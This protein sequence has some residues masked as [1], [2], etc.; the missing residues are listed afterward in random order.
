M[1]KQQLRIPGP[2]GRDPHQLSMELWYGL[3]VSVLVIVAGVFFWL[4]PHWQEE[5][6]PFD[7]IEDPVEREVARDRAELE[8]LVDRE[9]HASSDWRE[10]SRRARAF[11]VG[12]GKLTEFLC[13][14]ELEAMRAGEM[15]EGEVEALV[16]RVRRR[17]TDAPWTCLMRE[18][19]NGDLGEEALNEAL[20]EAWAEVEALEGLGLSMAKAV[21]TY[22]EERNRPE[23]ERF[24]RWLRRC[25]IHFEYGASGEC[26]RLG[27]Q[28]APE[29]GADLLEMIDEHLQEE[30]SEAEILEVAGALARMAK[31][32]QPEAWK[33]VE[34][35]FL[36]DYNVDF[37]LGS[38]FGLCRLMNSPDP[39]ISREVSEYL[40]AVAGATSRAAREYTS[41]RW[42][43]TCRMAFGDPDKPQEP[44]PML[45]VV[46]IR[47]FEGGREVQEL[48][49][50]LA[51]LIEWGHCRVEEGAPRWF[52]GAERWTGGAEAMHRVM[53]R[54][55]TQTSYVNWYEPEELAEAVGEE[56]QAGGL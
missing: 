13:E 56:N 28:L 27:R 34:T 2:E 48:D 37:R 49:Y 38:L 7:H 22:R 43:E 12:P 47:E 1:A 8:V 32:G 24:Y 50:S 6:D 39:R 5:E 10:A 33:V 51:T 25:A 29:Y 55:F 54:Y 23:N 11:E 31:V 4:V 14:R 26:Q 30:L 15:S 17:S 53:G 46:V 36:P 3:L 19:L 16:G 9:M 41:Y 21:A 44:V 20:G 45:G 52:C 40:G 18:Y 42:R 35:A